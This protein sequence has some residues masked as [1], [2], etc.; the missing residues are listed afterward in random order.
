MIT[1]FDA[2]AFNIDTAMFANPTLDGTFSV[3]LDGTG[4]SLMLNYTAAAIPEPSTWAMLIIGV[5]VIAFSTFR[6]RR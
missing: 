4:T 5:A 3:A 6:R 1:G 2:A